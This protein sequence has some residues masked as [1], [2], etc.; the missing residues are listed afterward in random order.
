MVSLAL[1]KCS[2]TAKNE[3]AA[4]YERSQDLIVC[5]YCGVSKMG[6]LIGVFCFGMVKLRNCKLDLSRLRH[7][8]RYGSSKWLDSL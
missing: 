4:M 2:G 8:A 1:G 6:R 5:E 3:C 7:L